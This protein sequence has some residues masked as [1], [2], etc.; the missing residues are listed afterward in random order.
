MDIIDLTNI[1]FHAEATVASFDDGV[2]GHFVF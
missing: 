1:C 2:D